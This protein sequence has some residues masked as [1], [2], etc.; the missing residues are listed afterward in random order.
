MAEKLS[1]YAGKISY[2]VIGP[3]SQSGR[4]GLLYAA[5]DSP[6]N[7][8]AF[9]RAYILLNGGDE[10]CAKVVTPRPGEAH[11]DTYARLHRTYDLLAD[12]VD[13]EPPYDVGLRSL[14]PDR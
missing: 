2:V 3:E 14:F 8:I 5:Y 1:D 13:K 6:E 7:A 9:A 10:T 12:A 11:E 4:G